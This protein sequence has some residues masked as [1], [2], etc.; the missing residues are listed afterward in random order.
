MNPPKAKRFTLLAMSLLMAPLLSSC[1]ANGVIF[2]GSFAQIED[3]LLHQYDN[4]SV[5][6]SSTTPTSLWKYKKPRPTPTP[7]RGLPRHAAFSR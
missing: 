3:L 4:S 7:I 6:S 5:V 1:G 2:C